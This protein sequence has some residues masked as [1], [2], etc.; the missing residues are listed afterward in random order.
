MNVAFDKFNTQDVSKI[1]GVAPQTVTYWVRHGLLKAV[2]V[3]EGSE[4][5]RYQFTDEEV[6]RVQN[7]IKKHGTR[8]WMLYAR[9]QEAAAKVQPTLVT[10][11]DITTIFPELK[12]PEQT[13]KEFNAD[14]VM[15]KILKLQDLK[16]QL[17]DIEAE[18]NQLIKPLRICA[19][20]S[21]K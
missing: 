8:N 3:G 14:K 9:D 13:K 12:A 15:N 7:L 19:R 17:E 11:K 4:K 16:E 20:K 2:N 6:T 21:W 18:R 1:F 5:A 10:Q